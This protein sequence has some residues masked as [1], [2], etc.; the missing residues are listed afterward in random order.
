M[1]YII[2]FKVP[3]MVVIRQ[4]QHV[5]RMDLDTPRSKGLLL[6]SNG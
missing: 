1:S 3:A 5:A 4:D 6:P 2:V